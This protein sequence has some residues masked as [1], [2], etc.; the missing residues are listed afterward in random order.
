MLDI[1]MRAFKFGHDIELIL[2]DRTDNSLQLDQT[3]VKYNVT[4]ITSRNKKNNLIRLI[5][6]PLLAV[7]VI[8]RLFK[9]TNSD[10]VVLTST[11]D[12]LVIARIYSL[13]STVRIRHQ[14]R[15]L[16]NLQL[17]NGLASKAIK[18]IE[19]WCLQRCELLIYSAP[20]FYKEYY[21]S[22][23]K[24]SHALL[25]NLPQLSTWKDFQQDLDLKTGFKIGYIGII[26]YMSP[27]LN[28]VDATERMISCGSS[29]SVL[30]AGG[31]DVSL[32]Q[33][34]V[35][36][37]ARFEFFGSF[38]YTS[39]VA[40]LFQNVDLIFAVYDRYDMNC[41]LAMPTKFYESLITRIPILVSS[42]TYVGVLVER[43]GIGRAVNGESA[44]AIL[45]VL[46]SVGQPDSWYAKAKATL[47]CQDMDDLYKLYE[48]AM[49]LTIS[50]KSPITNIVS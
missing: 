33:A 19:R 39:S 43:L 10:A 32:V 8:Y 12:M 3:L 44:D 7:R 28:L 23:Y 17:G 46:S 22:I 38:E 15:D 49:A 6:F 31:G 20:A 14:V 34:R 18:M 26:R 42:D 4:K 11:F 24:G 29:I 41:R 48:E 2:V 36:T 30:F 37:P 9:V 27:L 47:A 45:E 13:F 25:E 5:E 1:G 21:V 40:A 35:K 16:H 50:S